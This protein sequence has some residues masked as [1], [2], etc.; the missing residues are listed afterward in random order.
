M[1][2]Y[3]SFLGILLCVVLL[4]FNLVACV[5]NQDD[6]NGDGGGEE[7]KRKSM[8][9][10]RN[11]KRGLGVQGIDI[12]ETWGDYVGY[13]DLGGT[14]E[15]APNI[16]P[17]WYVSQFACRQD[18][19]K[20]G[21]YEKSADGF[22]TY[23]D[24]SKTF[25]VNTDTGEFVMGI[26]GSEEYDA[27]REETQSLAGLLLTAD[28]VE[29]I[30]LRDLSSLWF[31]MDFKL[32]YVINQMSE[33]EYNTNLHTAQF[34]FYFF[35]HD[36]N[37]TQWYHCGVPMY[38]YRYIYGEEYRAQ[39][40]PNLAETTN[41]YVYIPGTKECYDDPVVVGKDM[42]IRVDMLKFIYKGF[43]YAKEAGFMQLASKE[44]LYINSCS[45]GWEI[46]GTFDCMASVK[47]YD[48]T[49]TLKADEQ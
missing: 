4:C 17:M 46:P 14:A 10:D 12:N 30:M 28:H 41:A 8:L 33:S 6:G 42:S 36:N 44:N 9:I 38:D 23:K 2:K 7:V 24:E 19:T 15:N 16:D 26:K 37:S 35:V 18:I 45:I 39:D 1:R 11:F 40:N 43:D 21:T 22:H 49:Y 25:G 13:F 20:V 34:L 27:P 5:P 47:H 48:I 32:D 29:K 3:M 31:E